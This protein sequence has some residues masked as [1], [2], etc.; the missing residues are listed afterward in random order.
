MNDRF[1]RFHTVWNY[2]SVSKVKHIAEEIGWQGGKNEID[3]KFLS[4]LKLLT[5]KYCDM[6]FSDMKEK[7]DS[8]LKDE[9]CIFLF[10][11]IREPSEIRR[12]VK[13]FHAKSI[14][15]VRD[16][17]PPI[18]SNEADKNVFDC[19]YD[20]YVIN[21][22]TIEELREYAKKFIEEEIGGNKFV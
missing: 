17:V 14:L 5:S 9:N 10:L 3:R 21:N 8:F 4:D 22:G 11:H 2:S 19:N 12:A 18:K 7:V 1:K 15:V 16:N 13:E 6:P 20:I